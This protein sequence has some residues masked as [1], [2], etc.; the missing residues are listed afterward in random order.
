MATISDIRFSRI[1]WKDL[2][3][4][5]FFPP[6]FQDDPLDGRL[7]LKDDPLEGR[8]LLKDDP[9]EGALRVLVDFE[10]RGMVVYT[11]SLEEV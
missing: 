7:L 8:L 11:S 4:D 3:L 9:L 1:C 5:R 10:K 6:L 2:E